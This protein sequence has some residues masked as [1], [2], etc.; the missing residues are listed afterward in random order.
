[1]TS[2]TRNYNGAAPAL[3][4]EVDQNGHGT[5]GTATKLAERL[6]AL[7]TDRRALPGDVSERDD[8]PVL[9]VF[10][11]E[12]PDSAIG[13]HAANTINALAR[14]Q[15]AVHLFARDDF[16]SVV[17]DVCVHPVGACDEGT[18][19]GQVQ[20]FAHR[21][22]NQFLKLFTSGASHVTLMGYEWSA[23]PAL[24]ILHGIKNLSA[25]LYLHSLERQ[26]SD[27]SS[28]LNR[29][30]EE[31]ELTGLREAR[32][33][34]VQDAATAEVAKYWVPECGERITNSR[35]MFPA[36]LF[37]KQLDPGRI[38]ARYQVGPV[39]PTVLFIGD[40]SERYGP[41]MLIKALPA[42][43]KNNKQVRLVIVGDGQL[44]WPLRVYTRYLLLENAV[45]LVGDVQG[46]ALHELVQAADVIAVP[47]RESTPWWPIQAG[48]AARRPVV[49]THQAAPALVEHE[50]DSILF[51]PAES[52]CVWGI[53]RV[54]FDPDM[55]RR[56]IEGGSEKLEERFGWNCL[57]Q[58]IEELMGAKTRA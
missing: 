20:E 7:L 22:C 10:C 30:I 28:D 47:S 11:Y 31:I 58:Q 4:R 18:L 51:Y 57:A 46:E 6:P 14:R 2:R 55:S 24:S 25:L 33:I 13:R 49:A 3:D 12:A 36:H 16:D 34:I 9:A 15:I 32:S 48:W 41:D 44:Y 43:L 52:S 45:R 50:K 54:L 23:M 26:R 39:D 29:E 53:E 40:L 19:I 42:A 21:A 8:R 38:K 5:N 1:M 37:T 17:H 56:I 35:P 27:M